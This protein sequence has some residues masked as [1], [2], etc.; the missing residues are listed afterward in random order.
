MTDK[1][2]IP[3]IERFITWLIN[4][5]IVKFLDTRAERIR[6]FLRIAK[7]V[8]F[9]FWISLLGSAS[10]FASNQSADILR[11]IAEDT[12]HPIKSWLLFMFSGLTLSL[13]SWYWPRALIY[14]CAPHALHAQPGKPEGI[15]ARWLPRV[16]GMIPF[17]GIGIALRQ[18]AQGLEPQELSR[19]WLM[20][21]FWLNLFEGLIVAVGLIVRRKIAKFLSSRVPLWPEQ[22]KREG[23]K[24][25]TDLPRI[26]WRILV[27][28]VALA[29]ILFVVFTTSKGEIEFA[30]WLGT[31]SLVLLTVA[32]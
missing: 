18:A 27:F 4:T 12:E 17:I 29:V 7:L 15:A 1:K 26:T 6:R 3:I 9:S 23:A 21:L 14:R 22:V 10:L 2:S 30:S 11:V 5:L 24:Q 13:M 25:L 31:A 19:V 32:A 28:T 16:C 8:R 20:H